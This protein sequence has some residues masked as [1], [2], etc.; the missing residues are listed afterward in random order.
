MLRLAEQTKKLLEQLYQLQ[1]DRSWFGGKS[2]AAQM[3]ALLDRIAEQR[4]PVAVPVI[5]QASCLS[6][7]TCHEAGALLQWNSVGTCRGLFQGR[8][9]GSVHLRFWYDGH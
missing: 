9:R 7:E 6:K 1:S 4:E 8:P 5:A 3:I 2:G